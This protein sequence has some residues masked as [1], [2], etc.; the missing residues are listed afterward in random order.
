MEASETNEKIISSFFQFTHVGHW[1]ILQKMS[2]KNQGLARPMKGNL[3]SSSHN[4]YKGQTFI[5]L[6]PST[7]LLGREPMKII[8]EVQPKKYNSEVCLIDFID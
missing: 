8:S 7:N 2:E 6:A 4:G 5:N 1:F 3:M